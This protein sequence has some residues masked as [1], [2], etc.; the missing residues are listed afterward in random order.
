[1]RSYI[2]NLPA[3]VERMQRM[4]GLFGSLGIPFERFEAVNAEAAHSH[5][6]RR[7]LPPARHPWSDSELGCLLSHFEIWQLIATAEDPFGAVFEDDLYVAP[8]LARVLSCT[9]PL[10]ADV[11]KL[12]TTRAT[13]YR[14]TPEA[15]ISGVG[16]H[17]L[18]EMHEGSG[19]YL[20]SRRAAK[21]LI[22]RVKHF[23]MPVDHLLFEPL[24]SASRGLSIFQCVPSLVIQD[25][26]LP[27][28]R[29]RGGAL[30]SGMKDRIDY[31]R[32]RGFLERLSRFPRSGGRRIRRM[33]RP[34]LWGVVP[35]AGIA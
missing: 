7:S 30:S 31:V 35:F 29:R 28:G 5:P 1:M 16:L 10:G 27:S 17:R 32:P 26:V 23:D 21:T 11:I 33:L 4:V 19:G 8:S 2:I 34:T 3:A 15:H 14:T 20:I 25:D 12:E 6:L 24:H 13:C 22:S 18:F 9:A